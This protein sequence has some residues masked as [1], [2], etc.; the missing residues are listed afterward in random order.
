M[1]SNDAFQQQLMK[2]KEQG[3]QYTGPAATTNGAPAPTGDPNQSPWSTGTQAITSSD[4]GT[5][6]LN[7]VTGGTPSNTPSGSMPAGMPDWEAAIY[8]K[9]G[10]TPGDRGSGFADWQYWRDKAGEAGQGYIA[11]R[12][13]KDI[14]GTGTDRPTGTPGTG[15]WSSSGAGGGAGAGGAQGSGAYVPGSGVSGMGTIF[16]GSPLGS[17]NA[18]DLY[19]MLMKRANQSLQLDP[20]DPIIKPQVNAYE[21]AQTDAERNYMTQQAEKAGSGAGTN[22]DA[23]GRAA[24]EQVGKSTSGFQAGLMGQELT[25][26]RKEIQDALSGA[27]GLLTAEQAMQLQEELQQL[28]MAQNQYQFNVNDQFR[29]SPLGS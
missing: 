8:Q 18:N 12:L 6:P 19:N 11:D 14:A 3:A 28:G 1:A 27:Q 13:S 29:N 24:A 4:P 22:V 21:S 15:A 23:Q 7:T 25:A 16:G 20:N 9:G 26:R 2:M 17:G 5:L 10:L